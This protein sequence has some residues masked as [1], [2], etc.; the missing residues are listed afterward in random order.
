MNKFNRTKFDRIRWIHITLFT[1]KFICYHIVF[2]TLLY[3]YCASPSVLHNIIDSMVLSCKHTMTRWSYG[4]IITMVECSRRN[5]QKCINYLFKPSHKQS[6]AQW[7]SFSFILLQFLVFRCSLCALLSWFKFIVYCY[8]FN[9]LKIWI[10]NQKPLIYVYALQ[11]RRYP[12]TRNLYVRQETWTGMKIIVRLLALSSVF[13]SL[14]ILFVNTTKISVY[15][16][17]HFLRK[18]NATH[19]F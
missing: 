7:I 6:T 12:T 9:N 10:F 18:I 17:F 13:V 11:T 15:E 2:Q 16:T 3:I 1:C 5:K 14:M 8:A 19:L 4:L